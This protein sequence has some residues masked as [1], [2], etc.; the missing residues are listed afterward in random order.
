MWYPSNQERA[1]SLLVK[2]S[3]RL[4]GVRSRHAVRDASALLGSASLRRVASSA[5]DPS[6]YIVIG[7][8]T[9]WMLL[10]RTV[11]LDGSYGSAATGELRSRT[12]PPR[13]PLR[14]NPARKSVRHGQLVSGLAPA[15]LDGG[16]LLS[17]CR[18]VW[19][20][21]ESGACRLVLGES[22]RQRGS[23]GYDRFTRR[24]C[25]GSRVLQ[26]TR[27]DIAHRPGAHSHWI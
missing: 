13:P 20:S 12:H 15:P 18:H 21:C 27:V 26:S 4:S 25:K 2:S 22:S 5:L 19:Y 17:C 3:W 7:S 24:R 6:L 14:T 11:W 9:R 16:S 10:L 23:G 8:D 1:A